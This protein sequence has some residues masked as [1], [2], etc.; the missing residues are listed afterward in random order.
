MRPPALFVLIAGLSWPAT[1]HSQPL[2]ESAGAGEATLPS[3]PNPTIQSIRLEETGVVVLVSVPAGVKKITLEACR[4]LGR[5][6]WAP[7]AVARRDGA[8][9]EVT[10]R[11]ARSS[12]LEMLRVR[13]DASDPLPSFFYQGTNSFAG[14]PGS[15]PTVAADGSRGGVLA[16]NAAGDASPGVTAAPVT[17]SPTAARAVAE[18]DIWKVEGDTLYFFNQ[19]RGLQVIDISQPDTPRVR[20][21]L[22]LAAAGE[23]LYLLDSTHIV[24]LARQNCCGAESE[25]VVVEIAEGKI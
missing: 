12:E 24:L 21:T 25:V 17:G 5:G 11:L 13:G 6:D 3:G 10:F 22:P 14:Q 15:P 9:G 8:A 19:Y 4:K 7:K 1:A 18:S 16:F 20:G 2:P 23:Q